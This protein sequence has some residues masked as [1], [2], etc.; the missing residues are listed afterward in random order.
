MK[1]TLK[2]CAIILGGVILI[3]WILIWLLY[4]QAKWQTQEKDTSTTQMTMVRIAK[5]AI[6]DK[7]N[8]IRNASALQI[9]QTSYN[10]LDRYNRH[11]LTKGPINKREQV[12][13]NDDYIMTIYINI[14]NWI[15]SNVDTSWYKTD[16]SISFNYNGQQIGMVELWTQS[17]RTTRYLRG[18]HD[19]QKI[20][21]GEK[22]GLII[23]YEATTGNTLTGIA[24][25]T[26]EE[27]SA[28]FAQAINDTE[29]AEIQKQEQIVG[30][31]QSIEWS[32]TTRLIIDPII[33]F[34]GDAVAIARKQ[35]DLTGC[36]ATM[37][38]TNKTQ[39]IPVKKYYISNTDTGDNIT[40]QIDN[41]VDIEL[42]S[43][44][45]E[46][47]P[48]TIE[49]IKSG[50]SLYKNVPFIIEYSN[51]KILQLFEIPLP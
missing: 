17:W 31:V 18:I 42:V 46:P 43:T 38:G 45:K 7:L 14:P 5:T 37:S 50:R 2:R 33:I 21:I 44:N 9:W 22:S 1:K 39:C 19:Q 11:L 51:G 48:S 15:V 26:F 27:I 24:R 30:Y 8:T 29:I 40:L 23:S 16:N 20:K 28:V 13:K 35:Y 12:I 25:E 47:T 49:N 10:M 41:T 36:L 32:G 34:T 6:R 4:Y 3:V